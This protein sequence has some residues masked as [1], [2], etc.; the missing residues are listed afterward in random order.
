MRV[1][2][3]T[4]SR[5]FSNFEI[6]SRLCVRRFCSAEEGMLCYGARKLV[7]DYRREEV[8]YFVTVNE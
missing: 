6:S 2:G 4:D 7:E 3:D 8:M 1:K 5:W